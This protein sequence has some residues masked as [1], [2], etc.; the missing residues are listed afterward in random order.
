[1]KVIIMKIGVFLIRVMYA[2]MKLL[3][4]KNRITFMSRQGDSP[5]QDICMLAEEIRKKNPDVD[6]IVLTKML[7]ATP[8]GLVSYLG[9]MIKQMH[10][11]A[12][13][14]VVVL[15]GYCIPACI[16][17]HKAETSVI[18]MWHSTA[19]IKKFGYQTLDMPSGHSRAVAETMHMHENYDFII[20]PS[21]PTGK[22]F[23]QAMNTSQDKLVCLGLPRIDSIIKEDKE[24]AGR[25]KEEYGLKGDKKILLYAPTFRK[26]EKIQL[27]E[28]V[29][30]LDLD[31]YE[32][33]VK[34]H[35]VYKD[36][37]E[38]IEGVIYDDKYSSHEWFNV[39]DGII[40]DYSAVGIEAML[41]DKPV[42]FYLYDIDSYREKV[43]INI[44]L[45]DEM[46]NLTA[47]DAGR[48]VEIIDGEYDFESMRNF[49]DK[50]VTVERKNCTG[51]LADFMLNLMNKQEKR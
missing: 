18:Q 43:G 6:C 28:L 21:L 22:L 50:Y 25:I 29:K 23:C 12:T 9:H 42:Y 36:S 10:A 1:M 30:A 5:S 35:P 17:E 41:T 37:G 26:G 49:R 44:E 20:C 38:I 24:L 34:L 33:V 3:K 47:R 51:K 7:R 8:G 16:L 14:K 4:L 45:M 48:L 46:G 32:L 39:C 31:S 11:L 40:S 27:W 15:D 13:S 2:P 19:A